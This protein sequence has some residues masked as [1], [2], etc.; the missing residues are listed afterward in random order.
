[1]TPPRQIV[2]L[3][4]GTAGWMCAAAFSRLLATG[5]FKVRLIESD[6][7]GTVG[8]GEA[9]LPHIK[10]FNDS[11]GINEADFMRATQATFKLGIEFRD[12]SQNRNMPGNSYIH[13]F[14]AFGQNWAGVDFHHYWL[15]AQKAGLD[16]GALED[17]CLAIAAARAG[18]FD[19]PTLDAG[20]IRSTY[21]Y[22]Y[23]FDAGLYAGFM[24]RFATA[25]GVIRSEGRVKD[26]LLDPETGDIHGLRL[27]SGEVVEGDLFIDCSGFAALLI[28][29][30][31]D[32]EWQ[33]W[34][35]WLPCDRAWAVPTE[36]SGHLTPYTRATARD[37]GWQ[38]CIPLQHRTGNGYVFSSRHVSEDHARATLLAHLDG[39]PLADPRL[40]KFQ[41]GRRTASWTKNCIAMGLASG[42]LEPLESTSIYLVQI[43][44]QTL[45][46][47]MPGR[48]D[49]PRLRAEFNRVIDLEYDRVRD[50]LILHY[51]AAGRDDSAFW[52]DVRATAIPDSLHE[53]LALFRERGTIQT[54]RDG[55][56][57]PPSW[58]AVYYGQD[59]VPLAYNR[60]ADEAPLDL[61]AT[62]LD[63][64]KSRIAH[65]VDAMPTHE[66]TLRSY[67][68]AAGGQS[69]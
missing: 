2:I 10:D 47:L 55:L 29:K 45:L 69:L 15:R 6:D 44:I 18:R 43:A 57:S 68:D 5:R 54:Y 3:G 67:A 51:H 30:T 62:K 23:H 28:G 1:M 50:F 65:A 35:H 12:W 64:L 9:T 19:F 49:D 16:A 61:V 53:K 56:F 22:A 33:D 36:N 63:E 32:A 17:Y 38:W 14:G 46:K 20:S 60:M 66:S 42:F 58:L 8:V 21:A 26:V 59:V 31:L 48:D 39:P 4:G 11:L 27:A 40:L 52:R 37:A 7:I 41:A 13:P 24:R 34:S 25:R